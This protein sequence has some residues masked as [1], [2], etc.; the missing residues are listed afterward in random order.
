MGAGHAGP[1][2]PSGRYE[3]LHET[4]FIYAF[5]LDSLDLTPSPPADSE[6]VGRATS[7]AAP[8]R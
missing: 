7:G 2:G 1:S 6:T 3:A 8:R 4:A 5:L